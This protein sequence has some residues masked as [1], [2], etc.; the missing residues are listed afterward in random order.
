MSEHPYK[1]LPP[2]AFWRRA[3]AGPAPA[4]VDPV[5]GFGLTIG[6]ADHVA[7]A[8]SCF[9]QHIARHLQASGF[10]FFVTEEPHPMMGADA[11]ARL[12]YG[13]Y[14]ARF[15]NVYTSTQLLQLLRRAFGRFQPAEAAWQNAAGRWVDPFRPQINPDGFATAAEMVADR[16]YHLGCVRRM[17]E[18]LDVFVFTL[19][20]TERWT[21]REDGA[22]FPICPGVAGGVF[23]PA[24][25]AFH[26]MRASEVAADLRSFAAELRSVNP[27]A[28]MIVTVS[29]V[30]LVATATGQHVLAAT[31]QAK[32]A[33]RVACEEFTQDTP[34]T[35]Y[36]PSYEIITGPQARG[37][38]FAEDLRS[39]TEAGVSHVMRLFL[40]H[41]T[42]GAPETAVP[43]QAS[44]A[45]SEHAEYVRQMKDV[46]TVVCDEEALDAA[47][48]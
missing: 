43:V 10:Q 48:K 24:R 17:F 27:G 21:S 31:I 38:Y 35:A 14:S 3:V 47:V 16:D 8:G 33:L 13:V 7:T 32:S 19:G 2:T 11:L 9:A 41:C 5:V 23:D 26:T 28:R 45:R 46:V 15:G 18:E 34:G 4:D 6:R 40:R 29:P 42:A 20:L 39:V 1:D 22:A 12:Q 30:P 36:F 25:Y 37:G 44:D